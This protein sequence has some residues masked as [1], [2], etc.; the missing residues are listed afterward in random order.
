MYFINYTSGATRWCKELD[1]KLLMSQFSTNSII[2]VVDSEKTRMLVRTKEGIGWV[3][4]PEVETPTEEEIKAF[5][6]S[7]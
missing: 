7:I 3:D 2:S 4:L 5:E 6:E 1:I